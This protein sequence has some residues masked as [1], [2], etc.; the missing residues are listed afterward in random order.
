MSALSACELFEIPTFLLNSLIERYLKR[1][2]RIK[3]KW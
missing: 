1:N 3:T 2:N